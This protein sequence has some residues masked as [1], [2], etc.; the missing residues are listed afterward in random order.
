MKLHLKVLEGKED[1]RI[2]PLVNSIFFS[3]FP[4]GFIPKIYTCI[5]I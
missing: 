5:L 4:N 1:D 3:I 2:L